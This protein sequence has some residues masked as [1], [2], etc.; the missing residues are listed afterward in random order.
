MVD[1]ILVV[2][3]FGLLCI[4]CG[5]EHS[6]QICTSIFASVTFYC[7]THMAILIIVKACNKLLE[8]QTHTHHLLHYH[9]LFLPSF[10][11]LGLYL[12][13][14]EVRWARGQIGAAAASHSNTR[15]E[16]HLPPTP[17]LTAMP[18]P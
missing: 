11:F 9:L 3:R 14:M 15:S 8:R 7:F 17:Q 16:P 18:D 5:C 6:V 4:Y 10:C 2:S 12:Q 13:Y 1:H